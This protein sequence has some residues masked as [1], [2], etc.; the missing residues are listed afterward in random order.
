MNLCLEKRDK[1]LTLYLHNNPVRKKMV[2]D[3]LNWPH[4]SAA[5]YY[6]GKVEG[7][8]VDVLDFIAFNPTYKGENDV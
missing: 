4:S 2:K 5:F 8:E 1:R 3:A 6:L 7:L